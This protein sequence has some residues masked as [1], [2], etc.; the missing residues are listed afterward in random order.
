[1]NLKASHH[2]NKNTQKKTY[3]GE[4][5]DRASVNCIK[6]VWDACSLDS[7]RKRERMEQKKYLKKYEPKL[8]KF[9]QKQ[10]L[11][12]LGISVN[13]KSNGYKENQY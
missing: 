5:K 8:S 4:K 2:L 11:T 1:M 9:S 13:P 7:R 10:K 3:W 6:K 12:D